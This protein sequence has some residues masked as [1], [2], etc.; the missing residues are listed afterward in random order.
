MSKESLKQAALILFSEKGYDGTALSEIAK[1]A[2]IKTPSIYAHFE[3]K[4]ALYLTIY[5]EVIQTE[6][7][8]LKHKKRED[9]DTTEDYLKAFFYE[10]T[11][12]EKNPEIRRFFQRSIYY[13]PVS[14]K[15]KMIEE[16]KNYEQL[17]FDKIGT[18]LDEVTQDET[19]KNTLD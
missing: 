12:F 4:E 19:K 17:T 1:Q 10:A 9:Y 8:N 5:R 18:L 16:M 15:E 13:P 11:D 14:L 6:L 3:S 2:G 7:A